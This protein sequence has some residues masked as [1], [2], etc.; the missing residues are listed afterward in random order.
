MSFPPPALTP[1]GII[2]RLRSLWRGIRRREAIEAEMR[3]EFQHHLE[4]RTEDLMRREGLTRR[5]AY[6]RARLEFGHVEGHLEDAR[7]S[8]GLHWFD[9]ISFSWLDVKLGFRMVVR[10]PGLTLVS[11]FALAIGIPVGLAPGH[12]VDGLLAPLPV[13]EGQQIRTLRLWSTAQGHATTTTTHD[14]EIWRTSLSTFEDIAAFRQTAYNIDA[15]TGGWTVVRGAEVTASTFSVLRVAPLLGRPI[16]PADEVPGAEDVAVIGYDLWQ[17]QYGGDPAIVGRSIRLGGASRTVV[18]VMPEDF[19]F[20]IQ[21]LLWTPL[22]VA[23]GRTAETA[24]P[25]QIFGRL[26]EGVDDARA[27]AEFA[28]VAERSAVPGRAQRLQPQ[29]RPFAYILLPGMSDGL[30]ASPEFLASQSLALLVLL[31]A[32]TNVAMLVFARTATR[33]NELAVRTA[34][35]ASRARIVTQVFVECLVLALLAA[36]AGLL[37]MASVLELMWRVIPGTWAASLPYWIRWEIG[38]DT[39]IYA[40]A[41]AGVSAVVAG[42]IPALRFTGKHVQSTIQRARARRTGVRFGGL[43]G[44][45]IAVD[46]AVAV[47]AVGFAMTAWDLVQRADSAAAA[48]GVPADEYLAASIRLPLEADAAPGAGPAGERVTRMASVQNELVRRL[49]ED[50]QVRGVAV[51]DVLPRMDHPT[52][53]VKVEG[54]EVPDDHRGVTTRVARV[55]VDFFD[56]MGQPILMGRDFNAGDMEDGASTVIVNTTFVERVLGGEHAIGRRIRFVPRGD[57]EPGPWKEIVGVVDHLGM[58]LISPEND[59]GVY[60]PVAPGELETVRLAIH[61]KGDPLGFVPRLREVAADV[62]PDLI[63]SVTGPLD[64]IFEGDW[65]LILA[66]S[67]GAGLLVGVLLALAA[68]GIYAIMSFAVS[69]RTTE[70]GIRSA[71]GAD[72]RDLVVLVARRAMAQIAAGVLIGM[73]LAALFLVNDVGSRYVGAGKT[74]VVGIMV[75]AVVGLAACTGP[76]LRALRID[77]NVA[78]KGEG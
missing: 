46:V 38:A 4:L 29:V 55:A 67:L 48:V 43:S 14:Y 37:L 63:V 21:E 19:R 20:P 39:A 26:A 76:T 62:A 64:D 31:V 54:V 74:L 24:E 50:S 23:P 49:R 13:P 61:V 16:L 56:S 77:P 1:S 30:R 12:F 47:A 18:G 72:R 71:L 25:V 65:Y 35:G 60:L 15:E 32:C 40:L 70:I 3:E 45:L 6:R 10:R 78:L 11:T 7:A 2:A 69:E 51:A 57:G 59:Q 36:G 17:N 42:V 58:R 22:R 34:L 68:S 8:R 52:R 33:S 5:E 44:F 73:P 9:R 41:L 75:M 53:R 66:L 28:L 27:S